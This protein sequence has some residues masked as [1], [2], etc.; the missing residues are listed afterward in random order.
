MGGAVRGSTRGF[1]AI[2]QRQFGFGVRGN[3]LGEVWFGGLGE[4][5]WRELDAGRCSVWV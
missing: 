5:S 2:F 1:G 4:T 3:R